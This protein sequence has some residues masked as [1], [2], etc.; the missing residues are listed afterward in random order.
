MP[1]F[2]SGNKGII[3]WSV[4][5]LFYLALSIFT[6]F[7]GRTLL[8]HLKIMTKSG[9]TLIYEENIGLESTLYHAFKTITI[10]DIIGF[11]L[12]ALAAIASVIF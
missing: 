11:F 2:L 4:L 10:V 3:F 6:Y 5:A 8:K 9:D 7:A 1:D 12:A